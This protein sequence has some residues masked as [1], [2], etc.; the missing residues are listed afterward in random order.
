MLTHCQLG[1]VVIGDARC[2]IIRLEF[3]FIMGGGLCEY[4]G[5]A[6]VCHDSRV[7]EFWI[8]YK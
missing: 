5:W 6:G 7:E 2:K 8:E 1:K 3:M 4:V